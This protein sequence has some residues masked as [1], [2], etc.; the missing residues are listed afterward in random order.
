MAGCAAIALCLASGYLLVSLA[1]SRAPFGWLLRLSLAAGFGIGIFSADE[2]VGLAFGIHRSWPVDSIVF[3][4]LLIA[5][6]LARNQKS[7]SAALLAMSDNRDEGKSPVRAA[8]N[9]TFAIALCVAIYSAVL[10][11]LVHPHGD[12]WDAF[13]IW[14]LHARFLFRAG[15]AWRDGFTSVIAWSHPDYPLLLPASIAHFWNYLGRESQAA[16]GT[17]G[18]VFTFS[19]VAVLV[20]S[21]AILRGHTNAMLGGL[22]LLATPFFI[23]QGASQYADVPLSFFFLAAIVLQ[24]LG[25]SSSA[26][27]PHSAARLY[28]LAGVSAGLAAWTKNEGLLFAFALL[29]SEFLLL[30][31]SRLSHR[32]YRRSPRPSAGV[33]ELAFFVIGLVPLLVLIFWFKH[34][35]APAGDLFP[36]FAQAAR[37]ML[38]PCRYWIVFRWFAKTLLRFGNWWLVPGSLLLPV[39]Y[40]LGVRREKIGGAWR[41]SR[42]AIALG[43]TLAGYFAIYLITPYDIF[44]HLRNSLNRLFLQLWPSAVFLSFLAAPR[45]L[46]EAAHPDELRD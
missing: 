20:S 8:L 12:G 42:S 17:I 24:C 38:E 15:A 14:N 3:G 11:S 41:P 25:Q 1:V 29:I 31:R 27:D 39:F 40:F 44:W 33:R 35:I 7:N 36:G 26:A 2:I 28:A 18:L 16:P 4:L 21:L 19:T 5:G 6:F 30:T 23:E 43:L 10:R 46:Q 45:A 22:V 34:S 37:K 32:D 9:V 13:A